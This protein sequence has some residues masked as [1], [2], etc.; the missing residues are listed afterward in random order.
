M[1][2]RKPAVAGSFYPKNK[3]VL[4]SEL[5]AFMDITSRDGNTPKALIVPHAGYIYSGAVAASAFKTLNSDL[6][7]SCNKPSKII[8]LGPNH[9]V[10]LSGCAIPS[11]DAFITPLGKVSINKKFCDLLLK[12]ELVT[13]NDKVHLWEHSLEVQLPFLQHCLNDIEI[14]PILVGQCDTALVINILTFLFEQD[15]FL[16]VVSSDLSHFHPN[17]EAIK[18][19]Q[20]TINK[21][22]KFDCDIQPNQACGCFALNGFLEF[23]KRQNWQI[24]LANKANSSIVNS[25]SN[26]VVGYASFILY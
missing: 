15:E 18:L 14:I 8:L 23:S 13:T 5:K 22:L 7:K 9:R 25:I 24:E 11:C 1:E 17:N 10:G 19:D 26:E 3:K 4:K 6:S 12:Q 21:I 16:I 20:N 2:Y